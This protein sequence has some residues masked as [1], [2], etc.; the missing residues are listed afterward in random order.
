GVANWAI[1]TLSALVVA[2][3]AVIIGLLNRR[4]PGTPPAQ[5][6]SGNAPK[7]TAAGLATEG[8]VNTTL[9][10]AAASDPAAT[11]EA[12]RDVPAPPATPPAPTTGRIDVT[13]DPS[14]ARV[15][16]DGTPRGH[17]PSALTIDAGGALGVSC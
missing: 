13:S 3:T 15:S 7:G 14:G 11:P 16:I 1:L 4:A 8:L 10:K 12:T 9:G 5:T 2:Q 6:A 17:T